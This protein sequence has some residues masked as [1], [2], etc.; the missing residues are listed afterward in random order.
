MKAEEISE[1]TF[2]LIKSNLP[3]ITDLSC[4]LNDLSHGK[5]Y[6]VMTSA[7][8]DI[9]TNMISYLVR[10]KVDARISKFNKDI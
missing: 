5:Y 10:R 2:S 7:S 6:K 1:T 8:S 3:T 4:S 9:V